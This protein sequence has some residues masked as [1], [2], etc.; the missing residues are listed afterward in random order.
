VKALVTGITGQT[1]SYLAELLLS[2]GYEVGGFIRR[3]STSNYS[4]IDHIIKD[5]RI[6]SG[7]LCDQTSVDRAI[8]GFKPD[9]VY[10][11]A[12]QS[13][14][15]TSWDQPVYTAD[16]NAIG[17]LRFL[18][19]IRTYKPDTKFLQ[20]S[21]SEMFGKVREIPQTEK[22]PFY[23]RSPYGVAKVFGY[24]ITVNYRES[25]DLFACNSICFNMESP[26]RGS[27]FVT[28]K[29]VEAV[30]RI[31]KGD[32]TELRLGNLD[33]KRDWGFA[34]DYANAMWLMLQQELSDD[35]VIGSE[36]THSIREFCEIAFSRV[37]LDYR[38]F[39]VIDPKFFRPA[40]V[41]ILLSDST[42]ARTVLGWKRTQSFIDL[43]HTMVDSEMDK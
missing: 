42:K 19:S 26:R 9:E 21:T 15:P 25:Y 40:E 39:V 8:D 36:E 34:G 2:K 35:Y 12:A 20:S 7:D 32:Q 27:E 29:I 4:R 5:V 37:G 10:N 24:W 16:A 43:V 41:D 30:A 1:G 14:V 31:K 6:F 11:L 33:S 22:T 3:S 18:D 23:P 38:D 28:K 17:V 13:F